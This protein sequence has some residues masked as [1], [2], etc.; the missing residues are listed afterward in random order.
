MPMPT[1]IEKMQ[2]QTAYHF[3]I[4]D[5]V[6]GKL[7]LDGD[8]LNFLEVDDK[9]ITRVN[10]IANVVDKYANEKENQKY[11]TLTIDDGS[12]QIKVRAFGSDCKQLEKMG[13]GDT[14]LVIGRLRYFNN[15][16]YIL[17]EI[18]R[19]V[20][21]KWLLVRKLELEQEKVRQEEPGQQEPEQQ[22]GQEKQ[23]KQAEEAKQEAREKILQELR[24]EEQGAEID[25]LIMT[26]DMP[27]AQINNIVKELIEEGEAYEPKPGKIRLL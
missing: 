20:S 11:L 5:T 6:K 16:L 27:V 25:K 2:R 7:V 13:I 26:L 10:I 15:E 21:E 9:Q 3:S 17:P 1:E 23:K 19:K 8:R 4:G 14:I 12:A 22:A 18:T 24:K